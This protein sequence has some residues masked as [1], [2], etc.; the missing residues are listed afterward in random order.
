MD[1]IDLDLQEFND[2]SFLNK[3]LTLVKTRIKNIHAYNYEHNKSYFQ[4]VL[5]KISE[6]P[7]Y[8]LDCE[9]TRKIIKN[10]FESKSLLPVHASAFFNPLYVSFDWTMAED[11]GD[12][13][14]SG[15]EMF[16]SNTIYDLKIKN[17]SVGRMW[18]TCTVS[19]HG[20]QIIGAFFDSSIFSLGNIPIN[21]KIKMNDYTYD[22]I[23]VPDMYLSYGFQFVLLKIDKHSRVVDILFL[24]NN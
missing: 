20:S 22:A 21:L 17:Q 23:L 19:G 8:H 6:L 3:L 10:G 13:Q 16:A 15:I 24:T 18:P 1:S 7:C 12:T 9:N 2:S 14:Y 4:F 11:T 5:D